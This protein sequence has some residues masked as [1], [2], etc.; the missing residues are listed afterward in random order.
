MKLYTEQQVVALVRAEMTAR[1]LNQS[2]FAHHVG[3]QVSYLNHV[4]SGRRKPTK[5]LV[6]A[7]GLKAVTV[8]VKADSVSWKD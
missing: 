7:V 8:Y 5:N 4:L 3:M 6:A 2:Q 1:G